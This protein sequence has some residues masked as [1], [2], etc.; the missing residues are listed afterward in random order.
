MIT[1]IIPV[2]GFDQHDGF[3][4]VTY[5]AGHGLPVGQGKH[6]GGDGAAARAC[7]FYMTYRAI[8]YLL[9]SHI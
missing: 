8:S 4:V 2:R 9:S 3:V 5:W 7:A 1:D 6:S